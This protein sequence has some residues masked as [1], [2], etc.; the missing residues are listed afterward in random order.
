MTRE[1]I[2]SVEKSSI[3]RSLTKNSILRFPKSHNKFV[4]FLEKGVIEIARTDEKGNEF[5]K[6]LLKP[7]NLFGELPFVGTETPEDY[8]VALEDSAV[9]FIDADKLKQWMKENQELMTEVL[10]QVGTRMRKV[11][12]RLQSMFFKDARTR[13]REF[14]PEFV[15]EFGEKTSAGYEVRNFL[16][17]DDISKLTLTSRQTVNRV[18]NE[19]RDQHLIAYDKKLIRIPS[20]S[21]LL[22]PT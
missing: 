10:K 15:K 11:E 19:L 8:A 12:N 18:L 20:S 4:Y 9:W 7:G 5:I 2:E 17:H 21:K 14:I 13:A 3:R 1:E 6:Y 16:T 22:D